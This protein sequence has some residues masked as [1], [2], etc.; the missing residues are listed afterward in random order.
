MAKRDSFNRRGTQG[1]DIYGNGDWRSISRHCVIK[2]TAMQVATHSQKYFKRIEANKK[3]NRKA[4]AK[5]SILDINIVD[6]EFGG[7]Y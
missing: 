4:R 2:R 7:T 1:L 5:P 6:A 3:G